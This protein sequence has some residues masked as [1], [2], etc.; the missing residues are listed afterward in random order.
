MIIA[1][2]PRHCHRKGD[3]LT[4]CGSRVTLQRVSLQAG[5]GCRRGD[6]INNDIIKA[7][8]IDLFRR[9]IPPQSF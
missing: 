6:L 4:C 1:P 2:I 3:E 8:T 7:K 9:A 5:R